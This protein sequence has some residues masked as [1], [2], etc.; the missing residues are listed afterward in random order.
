MEK[1]FFTWALAAALCAG[2]ALTSC[3]DDDTTPGG[4]NGNDGSKPKIF[5]YNQLL[6][7]FHK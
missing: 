7:H 2:G 1:R 3:S 6:S 4:G 5:K